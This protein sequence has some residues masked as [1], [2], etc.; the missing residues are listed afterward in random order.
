MDDK[1]A[2]LESCACATLRQNSRLI[3]QY[4]ESAFREHHI[5]SAQFNVMSVL[6][7]TG[8]IPLTQLA[9]VLLQDRTGL[10]RNL[11]IMVNNGWVKMMQGEDK[12]IKNVGLT[13]QGFE[14]LDAV[15]PLWQSVQ[16]K[17]SKGYLNL[18]QIQHDRTMLKKL[19]D[20]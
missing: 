6:A 8:S 14:K 10:T 7:N 18:D 13:K 5:T 20:T 1:Y 9:E 16:K 2:I 15:I 12:R 4:Y 19:T 11:K 3:T 17:V